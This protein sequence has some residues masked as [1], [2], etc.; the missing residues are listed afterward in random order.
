MN[1]QQGKDLYPRLSSAVEKIQRQ[2]SEGYSVIWNCK[3]VDELC[4][5]MEDIF[6]HGLKEGLLS[7][8][9]SNQ[10]SF[11]SLATKITCK[12]DIEDILRLRLKTDEEKCM[13]WIR[14]GLKENTLGSYLNV[15]TQDEKLLREF[16]QPHAFLW[17]KE[18]AEKTKNLIIY[19]ISHLDF[20]ISL[21]S[22]S[23]RPVEGDSTA[24]LISY[25]VGMLSHLPKRENL[26]NG[27]GSTSSSWNG[28]EHYIQNGD[29]GNERTARKKPKKKK[30]AEVVMIAESMDFNET[31]TMANKDKKAQRDLDSE[32]S[33]ESVAS[34]NEVG[35]A[36]S[37]RMKGNLALESASNTEGDNIPLTM[38]LPM[39]E[40]ALQQ[41]ISNKRQQT[42]PSDAVAGSDHAVQSGFL[43]GQ[44]RENIGCAARDESHTESTVDT[45]NKNSDS[46]TS[47]F[48]RVT[49]G[50]DR[51]QLSKY[52]ANGFEGAVSITQPDIQRLSLS[53]DPPQG[54][55][56]DETSGASDEV[57]EAKTIAAGAANVPE[58]PEY[59]AELAAFE[60]GTPKLVDRISEIERFGEANESYEG[61]DLNI[62]PGIHKSYDTCS[63]SSSG[64]FNGSGS[65]QS[66]SQR[67]SRH[68]TL[69]INHRSS[70]FE[71]CVPPS[72]WP[73]ISNRKISSGGDCTIGSPG[74]ESQFSD[75]EIFDELLGLEEDHFSPPESFM[76]VSTSEELQHAINACKDLINTTP[77]DS[78]EK[79]KLISKLIQ[80]RLKLQ[81]TQDFKSAGDSSVQKVLGH[82]FTKEEDRGKKI[83]C[84]RCGKAIWMWQ[85][86]F[87]CLACKYHSHKHC[88]EL[89]RRACASRKVSVST[90]NLSICPEP[91]LSSQQYKCAECRK[92]IGL[93][94][95][96][97][98]E[99]RLCDYSGQY[100]CEEC[101]WNDSV[102]IPARVVHNWDFSLY[103]V[104]RQS[105]Q[106]LA[107]MTD[108]P[109]LK[110]EKLNPSLFKFVVELR[111]VKRLREEILIM[112][113]YF[114]I[115]RQALE[116]K[117]LLQLKDRQHFVDSSNVYS[118]QDL[119]DVNSGVLLPFLTKIHSL[120]LT[121]I[122]SDCQL[123]QAK[124]FVCEL[125]GKDEVIFAFD[126]HST[127]C[128]QCRTVFHKICFKSGVCPKCERRQKRSQTN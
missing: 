74:S 90:Y 125:C 16:Y 43:S 63:R 108:R 105:K 102:V 28:N 32:C 9:S 62:V 127:Q 73:G 4:F 54:A 67:S 122:K 60:C 50:D 25:S 99:A 94:R 75:Y 34:L 85:S 52:R 123:C 93:I 110:I 100:F 109:L 53:T 83:N 47:N 1:E 98:S 7:W 5:C 10:V 80:L 96:E 79:R 115:C 6:N 77:E 84:D 20:D 37:T 45:N 121:H 46:R 18:K 44:E 82:T 86:L 87:T 36:S 22:S 8:A 35:D 33:D 38:E 42:S 26:V 21:T 124:G 88:L 113:K 55:Q 66:S 23:K 56:G 11:W 15:I 13:A 112:K 3:V 117:L 95:G 81:E 103:K 65:F 24:P 114:V 51:Q 61:K 97:R 49:E 29:N 111:E 14:Q 30:K 104:S 57:L 64:S 128:K 69:E 126:P 68:N 120:F 40:T 71:G 119:I 2:I 118:L 41:I 31:G 91:G 107:L 12:K 101:H 76:G 19:G 92:Q 39:T 78:Q 59:H 70:Q 27:C 116:N 72:S 106:L 89:I 17:D 48:R 58:V